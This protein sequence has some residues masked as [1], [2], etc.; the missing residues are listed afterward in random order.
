MKYYYI[1]SQL[2]NFIGTIGSEEYATLDE[3]RIAAADIV[4]RNPL[5]RVEIW[6]FNEG[7]STLIVKLGE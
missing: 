4:S 3:A 7:E 6:R 1:F 2:A 5:Y